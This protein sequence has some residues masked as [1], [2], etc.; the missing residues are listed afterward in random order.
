MNIHFPNQTNWHKKVIMFVLFA[1]LHKLGIQQELPSQLLY[2][3]ED[4]QYR[5]WH[6][7]S[8]LVEFDCMIE[9]T[10][11][12][13]HFKQSES[14]EMVKHDRTSRGGRADRNKSQGRL[15][16]MAEGFL[17]LFGFGLKLVF[18]YLSCLYYINRRQLCYIN[19]T[20]LFFVELI[21]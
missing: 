6:G 9:H 5:H 10:S 18:D 21:L 16:Q 8:Y 1:T 3:M 14:G 4:L 7:H 15:V 2:M 20:G 19:G 11:L 13:L 12:H 17:Q